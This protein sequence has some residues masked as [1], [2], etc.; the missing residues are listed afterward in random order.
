[1]LNPVLLVILALAVARLVVLMVN[2]KITEPIRDAVVRRFG[3]DGWLTFGWHCMWCQGIWW[4]AA[5]TAITYATQGPPFTVHT[6]WTAVLTF[7]AVAFAGSY[8]ADR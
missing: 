6:L 2:D 7:L 8:L 5:L 4:S 3:I 1:M